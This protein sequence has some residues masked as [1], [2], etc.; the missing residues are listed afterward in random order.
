MSG[1]TAIDI[2][3]ILFV[4]SVKMILPMYR[5]KLCRSP[6]ANLAWNVS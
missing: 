4:Y 5:V 1:A 2:D 6:D 3:T